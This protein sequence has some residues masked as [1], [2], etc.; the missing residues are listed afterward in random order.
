MA[1]KRGIRRRAC[2]GKLQHPD[3]TAAVGHIISSLRR[4]DG[5]GGRLATYRCRWCKCWHVGH[6]QAKYV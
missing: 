2:T 5:G 3:Q 1:S 6:V 4:G